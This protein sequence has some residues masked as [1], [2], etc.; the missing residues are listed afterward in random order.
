MR[1]ALCLALSLTCLCTAMA[2]EPGPAGCY[3]SKGDNDW[4]WQSPPVNSKASI[5]AT[6]DSLKH[7]YGVD[8]IYWRGLQ[9]QYIVGSYLLRPE[10]FLS[11]GFWMWERHLADDVGTSRIAVQAAHDRGMT[12]WGFTALFDHG[13]QACSDAAKGMGPS[14]ME[15][16]LRVEHP[17]WVPQDRYGIRRQAGPLELAYPE[18]RARLVDDFARLV[19]QHNYDGLMF[20]GYVEHFQMWFQDEYGFNEPITAEFKRRYGTDIRTETFDRYAW[21]RLRGEYVTVFL[22][23]LS[24]RLHASGKKL[25]MSIDPQNTHFPQ[26]WLCAKPRDFVNTG[27]IHYDWERWVRE[28]IVDEIMVYC[29]GA[30]EAALNSVLAAVEGTDC[31]VSTIRGPAFLPQ[32]QHFACAGVRNTMCGYYKE[33][34]RGQPGEQPA[35]ALKGGNPLAKLRVLYQIGKGKTEASLDDLVQA[36]RDPNVLVR[37]QALRVLAERKDAAGLPAIE[38]ALGDP[39]HAVRCITAEVLCKVNGPDSVPKIFKALR[40]HGNFQ[41]AGAAATGLANMGAERTA[42]IVT[43]LSDKDARVRRTVAYALSRGQLRRE[44]GPALVSA[45]GDADAQV[46]FFAARALRRVPKEPG[47]TEAL[48][49]GLTDGHPTVRSTC[50]LGLQW[51][52]R[53]HSRWLGPMHYRVL[54]ALTERFGTFGDGY[55]GPD[56]DWGYRT[57]GNALLALG[58]RGK[59]VLE[60]FL[61]QRKDLRLADHAWRILN[62]PLTGHGY[63]NAPEREAL[64]AY[65]QHPKVT[66]NPP[67]AGAKQKPVEPAIVPYLTQ[68]FDSFPTHA[69]GKLGDY[70]DEGGQ[71][72]V[73]GGVHPAPVIQDQVKRGDKGHA[74]RL[75]R[76]KRGARHDLNGL[77]ADYRLTPEKTVVEFWVYREG[78]QSAFSAVWRDSGIG[79]MHIGLLVHAGGKVS[80][81]AGDRKW[82]ETKA[83]MP[84][85]T[86]Q[87]VRFDID[88][89]NRRYSV[90]LGLNPETVVA[91]AI[92][93]PDKFV[94][95]MLSISPQPPEG[96]T[97]YIDDVLV[98]VPNTAKK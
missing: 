84:A 12:I 81:M 80:V 8:R 10:N 20:Y 58:P 61:R 42:D 48:L 18:V 51:R 55:K 71:W 73:L 53:S 96:G 86:W 16:P 15:H 63:C 95:N 56:A 3:I 36:T 76:C 31:A 22:R 54:E 60:G 44:A 7:A 97:I 5:E 26:P 6:F 43:G 4:L 32:H 35:S 38:A 46:R 98:T 52:F 66:P 39:E 33:I 75:V 41:L 74:V 72:Q 91:E 93:L 29:N 24:K 94:C 57:V 79:H 25:G 30:T 82:V 45:M 47:S 11:Y 19:T 23:E 9:S 70:L 92:P 69:E 65:R 67:P 68:R 1:Q 89:A 77:R 28:G 37:R 62:V 27:R 13:A 2:Q 78:N 34:E 59:E 40:T 90:H 83:K 87:R 49:K 14:P 88:P 64:R 85:D 21:Y 50:A 17:E